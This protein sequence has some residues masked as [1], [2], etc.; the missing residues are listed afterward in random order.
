MNYLVRLILVA[1]LVCSLGVQ[2]FGQTGVPVQPTTVAPAARVVVQVLEDSDISEKDK[3]V[4]RAALERGLLRFARNYPASAALLEQG[5]VWPEAAAGDSRLKERQFI[6]KIIVDTNDNAVRMTFVLDSNRKNIASRAVSLA[7]VRFMELECAAALRSLSRHLLPAVVRNY[8]PE[9]LQ[10]FQVSNLTRQLDSSWAGMLMGLGMRR[11]G[12]LLAAVGDQLVEL[13]RQFEFKRSVEDLFS[14]KKSTVSYYSMTLSPSGTMLTKPVS[15]SSLGRMN[16]DG[17]VLESWNTGMDL[18]AATVL[19]LSDGRALAFDATKRTVRVCGPE[20]SQALPIDGLFE[21]DAYYASVGVDDDDNLWAL[22]YDRM[23]LV[24]SL[25]GELIRM[26]PLAGLPQDVHMGNML[27]RPDGTFLIAGSY[28]LYCYDAEGELVWKMARPTGEH[29]FPAMPFFVFDRKTGVINVFQTGSPEV[30]Q[31]WDREYLARMKIDVTGDQFTRER[32]MVG[33]QQ[34]LGGTRDA[35]AQAGLLF[36]AARVFQTWGASGLAYQSVQQAAQLDKNND[37][38][39]KSLAES[40]LLLYRQRIV[41]AENRTRQYL[42]ALGQESAREAYGLTMRLYEQAIAR[43]PEDSDLRQA[44]RAL[45]KDFAAAGVLDLAT[46]RLEVKSR[47]VAAVFPA[48]MQYYQENPLG[49]VKVRNSSKNSL[50]QVRTS[51]FIPRYMDFPSQGA[52]VQKLLPG[53]EVSLPLTAVLNAQVL[54]VQED[55]QV[56][57]QVEMSYVLNGEP[58]VQKYYQTIRLHRRTAISWEDSARLASFITPNEQVVSDFA[59]VVLSSHKQNLP[60]GL[61]TRISHAMAICDAL[62]LYGIAYVE[63]PVSPITRTLG[64]DSAIDTVRFPRHTLQLRSGDCDDSTALLA[65]LLESVGIPVAIMTT[66]GH[67]FLAFDSG[68]S[69]DRSW[70]Y[71]GEGFA[72]FV[73]DG[74]LWFPVETTVLVKGFT[75]ACKSASQNM[76][77]FKSEEV[78]WVPLTQARKQFS[79]IPLGASAMSILEPAAPSVKKRLQESFSELQLGLY[80]GKLQTMQRSLATASSAQA[81]RMY[82]QIGIL[83]ATFGTTQQAIDWYKEGLSRFPDAM[84]LY[85]NAAIVIEQTGQRSQAMALVQD[86]LTRKPDSPQLCALMARY[87]VLSG[88]VKEAEPYYRIAGNAAPE[89][90]KSLAVYFQTGS[91]TGT[92]RA[93]AENLPAMPWFE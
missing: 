2:L 27:P 67:V 52:A 40:D 3:P 72:P 80:N 35:K 13:D 73:K 15:G 92:G 90:V 45:A 4:L 53:A 39:K 50:A 88:K 69:P 7:S 16:A 33:L 63:D 18:S 55:L 66:P 36:A 1:G 10:A 34:S 83:H 71:S 68:E 47:E 12:S 48:L 79:P 81:A 65:S 70:L 93:S 62:G 41:R 46:T 37:V 5:I 78:E 89:M 31:L 77:R 74:S 8:Q 25:Q 56:Q 57:A 61:P 60:A 42:L 17:Q 11:D 82:N 86:G 54:D 43:V 44:M 91:T 75:A 84:S 38:Y 76:G 6:L 64:V 21:G 87:L 19:A 85:A 32:Y 58:F 51:L 30:Q 28:S 20:G 14:E 23:L 29:T 59:H 26:T 22:R 24:Y 9:L 49:F